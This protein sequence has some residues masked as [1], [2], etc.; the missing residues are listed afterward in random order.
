M[1]EALTDRVI[2][3]AGGPAPAPLRRYEP[4]DPLLSDP[5]LFA[6]A[7]GG[8]L[9]EAAEAAAGQ[10]AT[11]VH[12]TPSGEGAK[13][14]ALV[15]DASGV[16]SS[17]ELRSLYDFFHPVIRSVG[18]AGRVVVLGTPPDVCETVAESTAQ[19]A[20]EG[21]V[22]S[23]GKEVGS[24]GSTANLVYVEPGAEGALASTLRFLLSARSA[25][26]SGQGVRVSAADA[27][28]PAD[29]DRPLDGRTALVTGASRGIGEAI[30]EVMAR[31]GAH[32]V[33]L[34]VPPQGDALATVA[35]RIGGS[36]LQLDITADDAPQTLAD[37]LLERHGG[38]DA[39]IHNAGV[40]RDRTLGKMS[41][42][43]WDMLMDIN[44]SAPERLDEVLLGQNVLRPDGRIVGV[45]SISGIAGNRGQVNYASSKAG[46]IGRVESLSKEFAG[47]GRTINAVAPGFIDTQMTAAMPFATR[48]VGKRIN[49]LG[50]PG[51]PI[52]VAETVSW[53][54]QPASAGVNGN[55]VRVCGQQLIGK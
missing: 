33:C 30:A 14:G 47:S 20:L 13:V 26:V 15:F 10:D 24:R 12:E 23:V 22:R 18:T 55:V 32:V 35:N 2:K 49:S 17:R 39:V 36:A 6:G 19:R 52:D 8:R 7:P 45:S 27:A 4:G 29:W 53:F 43:E 42:D 28:A 48:E 38:V 40:T 46:V 16:R 5:A 41:E 25:Y 44:L 34:D 51:K 21:F 1:I 54:A 9:Q 50:Q 3:V 11:V 31:D 37:H